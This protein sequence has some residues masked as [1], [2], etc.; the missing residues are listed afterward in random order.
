MEDRIKEMLDE[1]IQS[2][3]EYIASLDDDDENKTKAIDDLVQLYKLRIEE[4]K[5][6]KELEEKK[7]RRLMELEQEALKAENDLKE[8]RKDR[9][10]KI[11]LTAAEVGLPLLFYG[12]WMKKGFKFEETGSFS[13][14]TFRGLFS[15]FKPTR[16]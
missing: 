3:I 5:N 16:K 10:I 6:D 13:S 7:E 4:S 12:R 14:T 15:K 9:I 8:Q 2:Q 1:R 11:V